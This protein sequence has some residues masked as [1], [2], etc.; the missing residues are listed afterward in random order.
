MFPVVITGPRLTLREFRKEDLDASMAVVGDPEVT[1]SLSFD[2]RTRHDQAERLAQDIARAQTEP[3][4][5]YYL[6][7]ANGAGILIGF[8]RIG[9]GRD[10]S[11]EIG[12]AVRRSDWGE[13]YATEAARLMLDFGFRTLHLHRIQAACGPENRASQRLLAR[14]G[15]TPEGRMRDHV[16]ANDAWRDSLLYSILDH[17]WEAQRLDGTSPVPDPSHGTHD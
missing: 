2:T 9:L 1:R 16:F 11:G 17:E 13:G 8:I 3:R 14:L 15:F 7:I 6:A 10:H 5:D 4:P 12:Y